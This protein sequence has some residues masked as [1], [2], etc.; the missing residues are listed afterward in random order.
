MRLGWSSRE[1]PSANLGLPSHII[2]RCWP[3]P[4]Y[5]THTAPVV[6]MLCEQDEWR[7]SFCRSSEETDTNGEPEETGSAEETQVLR[8]GSS[9]RAEMGSV[10]TLTPETYLPSTSSHY[11]VIYARKHPMCVLQHSSS[12]SP[13]KMK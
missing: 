3:Q 7:R 2:Q 11:S 8:R 9:L 10:Q 6:K 4:A 12:A 5:V 13:S 1:L